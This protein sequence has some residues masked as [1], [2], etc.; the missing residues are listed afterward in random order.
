MMGETFEILKLI[1][2]KVS[3]HP[4][5]YYPRKVEIKGK[6]TWLKLLENV[7]PVALDLNFPW[8]LKLTSK[9]F[10]I[11]PPCHEYIWKFLS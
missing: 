3:S 6:C 2:V 4:S 10:L 7:S 8:I 11:E 1:S 5:H 9:A